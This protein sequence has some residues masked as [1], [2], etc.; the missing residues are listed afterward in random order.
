[1]ILSDKTLTILN[2]IRKQKSIV[3]E[4]KNTHIGIT[5]QN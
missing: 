5:G 1:M 2:S 4:G 3:A